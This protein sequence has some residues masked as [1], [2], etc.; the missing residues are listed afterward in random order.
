M[1]SY[2]AI[3]SKEPVLVDCFFAF[4]NDQLKEGIAKHNLEGKK[5]C[6]AGAGLFGTREGIKKLLDDYEQIDKNIAAECDPQE[7]YDYEFD[8]HECSYTCE[9]SEAFAIVERIFGKERAGGVKRKFAFH[10]MHN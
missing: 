9:D 10:P 2:T 7:V 6:S 8:N 5:L 1:A 3:K 4:S